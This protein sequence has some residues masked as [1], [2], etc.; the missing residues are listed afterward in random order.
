MK[1][2]CYTTLNTIHV[3]FQQLFFKLIIKS[4]FLY[5]SHI[6]LMVNFKK[7]VEILKELYKNRKRI[8]SHIE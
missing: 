7:V 2:D 8:I 4:V 3:Q 6:Y 1:N 5:V